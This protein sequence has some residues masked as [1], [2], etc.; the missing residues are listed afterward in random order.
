M[1][2]LHAKYQ[3]SKHFLIGIMIEIGIISILILGQDF[4]IGQKVILKES[5]VTCIYSFSILIIFR[6]TS[7]SRINNENTTSYKINVGFLT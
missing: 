2:Y 7:N 5:W 4:R 1:G 3:I 6:F